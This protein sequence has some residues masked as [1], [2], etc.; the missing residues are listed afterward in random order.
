M[1]LHGGIKICVEAD[2][3]TSKN[4]LEVI[5]KEEE[6]HINWLE[7]QMHQIKEVGYEN[8]LAQQINP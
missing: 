5:L 4:L 7:S 3:Q 8:Y 1:V 2:D 6:N